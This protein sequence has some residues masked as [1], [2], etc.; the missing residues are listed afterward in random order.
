M[1]LHTRVV[2]DLA[3]VDPADWDA[4]DHGPSP[5]TEGRFPLMGLLATRYELI[6]EDAAESRELPESDEEP[7]HSGVVPTGIDI[8]ST[9]EQAGSVHGEMVRRY[10][11]RVGLFRVTR[12]HEPAPVHPPPAPDRRNLKS[13]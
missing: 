11:A 3:G 9:A 10:G 13:R 6:S 12:Y 1:R 5:F 4:L 2:L 7:E 8:I